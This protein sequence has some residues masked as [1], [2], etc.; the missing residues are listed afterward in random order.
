[1]STTYDFTSDFTTEALCLRMLER[2]RQTVQVQKDHVAVRKLGR[3]VEAILDLSNRQG[4][5][6][7]SLRNLSKACGVSMGG[8]YSY[9]DSKNTLLVM[10]LA[11]VSAVTT[12]VL[13]APPSGMVDRPADHLDWLIET[14]I[15]LTEAM[16]PWFVFAFMEAKSFPLPA[17]RMATDSEEATEKIIADVLDRGVSSGIFAVENPGL[18]AAL[19]KPLL[20]DWYVKRSKHRKRGT[21]IERYIAGVKRF[22]DN[23]IKVEPAIA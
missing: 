12:E 13:G 22:V 9:F 18:T 20:Q 5:H 2:N 3:I 19:I 8:M 10:I 14:H 11:E 6:A 7:T 4:F 23:A 16:I 15:R 21:S 1:M 17:R